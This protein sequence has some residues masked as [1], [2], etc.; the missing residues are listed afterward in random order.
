MFQRNSKLIEVRR[1]VEWEWDLSFEKLAV[2]GE[3][4]LLVKVLPEGGHYIMD[5]SP[6]G[7]M[8]YTRADPA[9]NWKLYDGAVRDSVMQDLLFSAWVAAT[10]ARQE[11]DLTAS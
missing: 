3:L 10:L 1:F 9:S 11:E 8:R 6:E 7:A 4:R 5:R 2:P